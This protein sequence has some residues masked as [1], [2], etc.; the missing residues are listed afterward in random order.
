VKKPPGKAEPEPDELNTE[1]Q[2]QLEMVRKSILSF[3]EHGLGN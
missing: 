2:Q 1:E 3:E